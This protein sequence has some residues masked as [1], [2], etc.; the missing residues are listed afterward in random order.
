MFYLTLNYLCLTFNDHSLPFKLQLFCKWN[1]KKYYF[2]IIWLC[3]LFGNNH[4]ISQ[5]WDV[6]LKQCQYVICRFPILDLFWS[7]KFDLASK[8]FPFCIIFNV[9]LEYGLNAVNGHQRKNWCLCL[10]VSSYWVCMYLFLLKIFFLVKI[11]WHQSYQ[12]IKHIL[13]YC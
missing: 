2:N 7:Q 3:F 12:Q 11:T 4:P 8:F 5:I 9:F 13:S 10:C 1:C 6:I